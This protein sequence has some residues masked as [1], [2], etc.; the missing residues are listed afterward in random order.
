MNCLRVNITKQK[1]HNI[2]INYEIIKTVYIKY[3]FG[4]D[5]T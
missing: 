2:E 4:I 1:L 5:G 3:S